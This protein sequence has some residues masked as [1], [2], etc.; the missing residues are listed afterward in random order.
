M[1]LIN[2]LLFTVSALVILIVSVTVS[3][4]AQTK[5]VT[6]PVIGGVVN[7]KALSLPK[8]VY[9]AEAR[10]LK[11]AG[12]IKVRVLIDEF[13]VVL[14]ATTED[15]PENVSLRAAAEAAA[16]QAKFSPTR[17]SGRLVKVSGVIVYNFVLDNKETERL[18]IMGVSAFLTIARTFVSNLDKFKDMFDESDLFGSE[19]TEYPEFA[20]DLKSLTALEKMP[21]DKR[22][23]AIDAVLSQIHSRSDE[24][25]RW[26]VDAGKNLGEVFGS[27]MWFVASAND[28]SDLDKLDV[29]AIKLSL[30]K[31]DDFTLTA[32]TEIPQD[33]LDRLKDL[34]AQGNKNN[35]KTM[36]D[37]KELLEKIETL[38]DT[39]A[40]GSTK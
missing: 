12:K 5:I 24:S 38:I 15:G 21:V 10:K 39:I 34:S 18:P 1:N 28:L 13:G 20:A 16:L 3:G 36:A 2:R 33:I 27:L 40:P 4:S 23:G 37:F 30:S 7:G 9:P 14:S 11:L 26:Q 6:K 32:P 29:A 22:P 19:I 8:P 35:L 25:G 17:L 31:L